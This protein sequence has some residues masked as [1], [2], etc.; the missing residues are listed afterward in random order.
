MTAEIADG[1]L[2]IFFAPKDNG[3][4]RAALDEALPGRAPTTI[5]DFEVPATVITVP[6]D[7]V[8]QAADMV[9]LPGALHP[10]GMGAQDQNFPLRGSS[11]GWA[12]GR[13]RQDPRDAYLDGPQGRAIAMP[14]PRWSG[15]LPH[16]LGGQDRDE[17]QLL[18]GRAWSPP[19]CSP[20]RP[21]PRA[22]SRPG[23]LM[24]AAWSS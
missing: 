8:E 9:R 18:G 10:G 1:W 3:F 15:H 17:L 22:H 24:G 13:L 23:R 14:T 19:S 4:Y 20:A 21:T 11:R 6:I 12:T 2:P 7:D 16:R 5:D